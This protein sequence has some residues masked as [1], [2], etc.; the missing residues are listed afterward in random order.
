MNPGNSLPQHSKRLLL[1]EDNMDL[2]E[3]LAQYLMRQGYEVTTAGSAR[4]F[5]QLA[6]FFPVVII[7]IGLPDQ[8][9]LVLVVYLRNNSDS[10]IIILTAQSSS[11]AKV[12]G[13]NAGADIYMVKPVDGKEL[14]ASIFNMFHRLDLLPPTDEQVLATR[15][16]DASPYTSNS[17]QLV[18]AG[19][20]LIWPD[21][22]SISLTGKEFELIHFLTLQQG[23]VVSRK[24]LLTNLNYSLNE[25]GNQSFEAQ[26]YRLRR[27]AELINSSLPIKTSRGIGYSLT[28]RVITE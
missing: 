7:D 6:S 13:Y 17:W 23:N 20:L 27:K 25:S 21:G 16:N 18:R 4:E 12:A 2:R 14:A 11:D 1:V 19:W 5:Y 28:A 24:N 22:K 8:S 26:I 9:G 10:K 15:E 3:D